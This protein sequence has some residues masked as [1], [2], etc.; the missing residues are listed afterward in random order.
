MMLKRC[1]ICG[2]FVEEEKMKIYGDGVYT[3]KTHYCSDDCWFK[4]GRIMGSKLGFGCPFFNEDRMCVPPDVGI[5]EAVPC[6]LTTGRY[7][8][9]FVFPLHASKRK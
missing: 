6:S 1:V 7:S 9:C 4:R 2:K 5:F 8:S 3:E